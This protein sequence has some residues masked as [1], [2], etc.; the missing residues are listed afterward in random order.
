MLKQT[1]QR[2]NEIPSGGAY[3]TRQSYAIVHIK[4]AAP[5]IP[6]RKEALVKSEVIRVM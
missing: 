5:L 4:Q 3:D 1:R 6:P 2:I